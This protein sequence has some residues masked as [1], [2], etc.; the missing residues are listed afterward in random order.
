MLLDLIVID[1]DQFRYYV[2]NHKLEPNGLKTG[3]HIF[4]FSFILNHIF[5]MVSF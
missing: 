2:I 1:G 3:H 4:Y 5:I